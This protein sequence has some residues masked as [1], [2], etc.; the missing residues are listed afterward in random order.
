[1][2]KN[3][4]FD[5]DGTLIDCDAEKFIPPYRRALAEKFA[6]EPNG[7]EIVR[8]ILGSVRAMVANDGART[9]REAFLSYAHNRLSP[10]PANL[11]A[12]MTDF[13][14]NEYEAVRPCVTEKPDMIE[15]VRLLKEKGY[16]LAVTT[17]P[18]FPRIALERRLVWGGLDPQAFALVT[19]YETCRYSKPS[20]AYYTEALDRLHLRADETLIVGN[21][22][23][24]DVAAGKQAGLATYYLT[25]FPI[26]DPTLGDGDPDFRGCSADFLRFVRSLPDRNATE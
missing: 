2:I 26:S 7:E 12:R 16:L 25:D 23:K 8:T 3:I 9:N 10:F 5:M 6:A 22:A 15:S 20:A 14:N 11:E 17:N 24:E 4:F 18:L 13:Y 19:D 1:M 21:D